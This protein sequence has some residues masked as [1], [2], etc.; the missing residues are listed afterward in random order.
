MLIDHKND[1][2]Y[3]SLAETKGNVLLMTTHKKT[4]FGA[5]LLLLLLGLP[6]FASVKESSS[7]TILFNN[8]PKVALLVKEQYVDPN[9]IKPDAMLAA[10]LEALELRITKLVVTLPKSLENALER[11]R[12]TKAE[13]VKDLPI[14]DEKTS[15]K[16]VL[17]LGGTIKSFDYEPQRSIWGTIF[18]LRD[19]FKFVEEEAKKQGLTDAD[20]EPLDWQ[21]I[22]TNVINAMLGTLDPHSV[23][24][25]P[26]YARD[27]TLTTK[28][29][30]GGIGIVISVRKGFLTVI[31]SI[32]G[33]P[34]YIAGVKAQDSIIKID[35]DSAINMDLNDAVNLL[36]GKPGTT[37]RITVK[38]ENVAKELEF[39]LK[40]AIIKVDSVAYSLLDNDIGYLKI[41]AFQGNTATD[42]KNGILAMK[43]QSKDKMSGLILDLRGNP[44]GLLREAVEISDLFL[45]GK[46]VVSTQGARAESKQVE[47]AGPG[48]LDP[49]LKVVVLTDV[50]SASASEIVA[51]ALK[52]DRAV[53]IGE[54]T[55]GKGSVQML[56]DFP[57]EVKDPLMKLST[58]PEPV[59][60]AALKLTIAEYFAPNHT[61]MQNRGVTPDGYLEPVFAAKAEEIS[62]FPEDSQREVDL[63]GHLTPESSTNTVEESL[64]NLKF[65]APKPDDE[66]AE[67]SKLNLKTLKNDFFVEVASEFIKESKGATRQDLL[68]N[69][70]NIK[71]K[72][73]AKEQKK[74]EE[75]LKKYQIDWSEG[76]Q[77]KIAIEAKVSE[78]APTLAGGKLKVSVKVK[79]TS[80]D[81]I[82]QLHALTHSKTDLF[83]LKEFLFGKLKPGQEIERSVEFE[84]PNDVVTRKDL[85]TLEFRDIKH[86]KINELV[87]PLEITGLGRPRLAYRLYIDDKAGNGDGLIETNEDVEL[88]LWLKNIGD[89][90]AFEPTVLLRNES[91]SAVFLKNGRFQAGELL[92]NQE[93]AMKFSFRVKEPVDQAKFEIQIFDGKMHDIWRDKVVFKVG[94]K[95]KST[96]IKRNVM[97]KDPTDLLAKA[98]DGSEKIATIK[99]GLSLIASKEIGEYLLVT[100]DKNLS[101]FVKKTDVKDAP[102]EKA[103]VKTSDFYTID[104]N[105]MPARISLKFADG[106]GF[107]KTASGMVEVATDK[108]QISDILLYVNGKKVLYRD[109]KNNKKKLEHK[110]N[111]KPGV[112]AISVFARQDGAFGQRENITVYYDS[113]GKAFGALKNANVKRAEK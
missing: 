39:V 84:I 7:Q 69:A 37:V 97:V 29:E 20:G 92:P 81:P 72:L 112:N 90:R 95:K 71:A 88:T 80:A 70:D 33:T 5:W 78:N 61:S 89:G 55:F 102:K 98:Y 63:L 103:Q 22:E 41:K 59:E 58:K 34:A 77:G 62:L 57:T 67:Y 26:K 65:L 110:I 36:R 25:E 113:D 83:N 14:V 66:A 87:V 68:A 60:P 111:L 75:A 12:A 8:L 15:E 104:Y 109:V 105:R 31:S 93:T 107:S 21:K 54:R 23:Y 43:K 2:V 94:E 99:P 11:V 49:R 74:I 86:E 56:F 16:L 76:T 18:Y 44:G 1:R 45:D 32:D 10:M 64:I 82:Y 17:D 4:V 46:E 85:M 19:I 13:D 47:M 27:L 40:R 73:T 35:D 42:V 108:D 100:V 52:N 9:R 24:L 96:N 6:S 101:G 51:G 30:F 50:G 91:G 106:S 79:N 48:E 38:R 3:Y 28:G 53:I